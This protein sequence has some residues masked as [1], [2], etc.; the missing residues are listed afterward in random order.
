MGFWAGLY[1]RWRGECN[2][3]RAL[4]VDRYRLSPTKRLHR[5]SDGLRDMDFAMMAAA[6]RDCKF[7]ADLAAKS[8]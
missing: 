5:C 1:R 2:N 3:A 6:E 8:R 7:I 4:T